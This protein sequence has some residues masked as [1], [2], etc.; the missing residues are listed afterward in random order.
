MTQ[1]NRVRRTTREAVE[2]RAEASDVWHALVRREETPRWLGPGATLEA[3]LG[4]L[5]TATNFR[6]ESFSGRVVELAATRRLVARGEEGGELDFQLD[7]RPRGTMVR[8]VRTVMLEPDDADERADAE[9]RDWRLALLALR[10][11]VEFRAELSSAHASA[12]TQ[13][14]RIEAWRALF[15]PGRFVVEGTVDQLQRRDGYKLTL[16]AG[17]Q[18]TGRAAT[19]EPGA[20]FIGDAATGE[21]LTLS[22]LRAKD[23]TLLHAALIGSRRPTDELADLAVTWQRAL[24]ACA[25]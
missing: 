7:L 18:A 25:S 14:P 5:C 17:F 19:I 16:P 4:G 15:G 13:A 23:R 6:G 3:K 8:A 10:V 9:P 20:Q 24:A 21:L 11:H 12:W 2:I 1:P 22:V